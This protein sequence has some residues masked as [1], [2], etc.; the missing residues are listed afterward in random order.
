MKI[1]EPYFTDTSKETP[2]DLTITPIKAVGVAP[3]YIVDYGDDFYSET[4]GGAKITPV[5]TTK[6]VTPVVT[7]VVTTNTQTSPKVVSVSLTG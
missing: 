6:A 2:I 4:P 1:F 5:G 7:P 3:T